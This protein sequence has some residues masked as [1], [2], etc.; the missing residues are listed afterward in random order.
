MVL[1]NRRYIHLNEYCAYEECFLSCLISELE[2]KKAHAF[3][4]GFFRFGGESGI[5]T[6][7]LRI[8]IPSL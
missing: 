5:R 1:N 3:C 6:P 4:M 2:S 8:M 7:D